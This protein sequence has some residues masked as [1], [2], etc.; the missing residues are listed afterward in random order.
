MASSAQVSPCSGPHSPAACGAP[1]S[2]PSLPWA[3]WRAVRSLGDKS[4]VFYTRPGHTQG[5]G[6]ILPCGVWSP[7]AQGSWDPYWVLDTRSLRVRA[8]VRITIR[9]FLLGGLGGVRVTLGG[10]LAL[11]A[12]SVPSVHWGGLSP[13]LP[14][15]EAAATCQVLGDFLAEGRTGLWGG[16]WVPLDPGI[17]R[18]SWGGLGKALGGMCSEV[19]C[20][21]Q[22]L[23]PFSLSP[24]Q[25]D[26]SRLKIIAKG[27]GF[28]PSL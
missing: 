10:D 17:A 9:A 22:A 27:N 19:A 12:P 6:G 13:C 14:G 7:E 25:L 4:W 28:V 11:Q 18:M 5:L 15:C 3:C 1:G 2:L 21:G 8:R 20:I 16:R 23:G 26:V 24:E